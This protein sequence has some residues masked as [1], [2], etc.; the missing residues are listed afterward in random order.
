[1]SQGGSAPDINPAGKNDSGDSKDS[2]STGTAVHDRGVSNPRH[3]RL[4]SWL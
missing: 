2:Y 4:K 3:E 1:M